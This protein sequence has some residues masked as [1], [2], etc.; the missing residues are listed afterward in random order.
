VR[1]F[2]GLPVESFVNEFE[3]RFSMARMDLE[4]KGERTRCP[5]RAARP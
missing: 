2:V 5:G 3:I 4:E 1:S